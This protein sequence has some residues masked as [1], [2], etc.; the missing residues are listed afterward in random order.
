[1]F[2]LS[3]ALQ[4]IAALVTYNEIDDLA[5]V[6][7]RANQFA[8][9][10]RPENVL[11][12]FDLDNTLLAMNQ[13]LG[14]DQWFNWQAGLLG[15]KNSKAVAHD[16][17]G[18]LAI[19]HQLFKLG[20]MRPTQKNVAQI[21]REI[22]QRKFPTF[23]LTSRGPEY[24]L[25]THRELRRNQLHFVNSLPHAQKLPQGI[26]FPDKTE[27]TP[28]P[29]PAQY[30]DGVLFI[31]GQHKG[32]LL[33]QLLNKLSLSPKAIVFVDDHKKH[34]KRISKTFRGS[35]MNVA[36]FRYTSEDANVK[37]FE[38][39]IP[40]VHQKWLRLK[41]ILPV[42]NDLFPGRKYSVLPAQ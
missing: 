6:Q 27:D 14:S 32:E 41:K 30:S 35:D 37:K 9:T 38:Q 16:F 8:K 29:R 34:N 12:I 5:K 18:L 10:H 13:P 28:K 19:Q 36:T 42:L 11:V 2:M 23:V 25:P 33:Q 3:P 39:Q 15:S 24:L 21:V 1:M 26:F 17:P 31:S 4:S 22:Q 40:K 20:S 7:R